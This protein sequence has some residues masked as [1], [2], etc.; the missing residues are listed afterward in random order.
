MFDKLL[1]NVNILVLRFF[2][3]IIKKILIRIIKYLWS[4]QVVLYYLILF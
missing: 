1:A 2:M 3:R 4:M